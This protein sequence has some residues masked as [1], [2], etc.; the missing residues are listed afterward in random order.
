MTAY[1]LH[2]YYYVILLLLLL[3][4]YYYY[5]YCCC[6][7]CC[8]SWYFIFMYFMVL[9]VGSDC[10]VL[11]EYCIVLYIIIW[12]LHRTL[13]TEHP[14]NCPLVHNSRLCNYS[15]FITHIRTHILSN[16]HLSS[17]MKNASVVWKQKCV[18]VNTGSTKAIVVLLIAT[19]QP[20]S[21]LRRVA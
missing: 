6:C 3:Y 7:C 13:E 11:N 21:R 1:K 18:G 15:H 9:I 12:T 20:S 19:T 4:Y 10:D 17:I 2:F 14:A 5:Y 8:C 16:L